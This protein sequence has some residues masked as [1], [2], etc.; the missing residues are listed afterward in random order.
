[1]KRHDDSALQVVSPGFI[2]FGTARARGRSCKQAWRTP[3][4]T[5]LDKGG[6]A[7]GMK[8]VLPED[9]VL[10]AS[11][12]TRVHGGTVYYGDN[13]FVYEANSTPS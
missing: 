10:I 4:L 12:T 11:G 9:G 13:D 6:A 3:R 7:I 5:D 1:M 2:H 8:D